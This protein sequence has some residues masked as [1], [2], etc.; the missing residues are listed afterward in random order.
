MHRS[1]PPKP[2]VLLGLAVL[3]VE[4]PF[5]VTCLLVQMLRRCEHCRHEWLHWPILPGV[6]PWHFAT[7]SLR[8]IP[9]DLSLLQV[10]LGWGAFTACLVAVIFVASWRSRFWRPVLA[11]G[12]VAASGLA[13]LTF[14][15]IAA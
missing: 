7:F 12:L 11:A 13:V 4:L 1:L 5:L 3:V 15:I 10:R 6:V 8:L 14:L 9:R 2:A